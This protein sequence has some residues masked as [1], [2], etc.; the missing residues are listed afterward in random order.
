MAGAYSRGAQ[1]FVLS[2]PSVGGIDLR[3]ATR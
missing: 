1:N 2:K 3:R